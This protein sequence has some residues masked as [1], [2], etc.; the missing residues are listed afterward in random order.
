MH[1]EKNVCESLLGTVLV[2]PHKLKDTDNARRDL[3]KLGIRHE[4]HLYRDGNKLMK[5]ASEYTFSEA[6]RRKFCRFIRS[7]KC[8][9]GFASN[10]SKNVA[11]NDSR[12]VG[13]KLHDCHVIM[14]R[15]LPVGCQSLVSKNI[16]ST[17]VELCTFFKQLCASIVNVS[18]MVEAQN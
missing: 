9:D 8:S 13:L 14:Q 4:L 5:L 18:D 6:N 11:S 2:D 1:I 16:W 12:L 15:L 3:A 10:L 17:I 7:V